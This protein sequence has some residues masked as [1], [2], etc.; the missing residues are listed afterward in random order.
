VERIMTAIAFIGFGEVGATLADDLASRAA[1]IAAW[2]I[3]FPDAE[4][5]PSQAVAARAVR[6]A[7][8]AADALHGADLI[9]SAVTAAQTDAAAGDAAPALAAGAIFLDLNSASP[10][11]K[12]AAAARVNDAGARYIEAAVM[13][14][15]EPKRIAAP[16][17]LGGPYA[18]AVLPLLKDFGFAGASFYSDGYGQAAAAKLC[19][20]I[21]IKGMEALLAE[22]LLTARHYG[23]ED[24]VLASLSNLLP[25]PDWPERARYMI[26]RALEHGVRRAEEMREAARTVEEAGLAPLLS[27]AIAQRQDWAATF[28][29]ALEHDDLNA[30]L[31]A[32]RREAQP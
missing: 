19:R 12:R 29:D 21:V 22:S 2:D 31:D 15:I 6:K 8:N 7:S 16:I 10:S 18:E 3:K 17:L 5:G 30:M 9:I 23:V 27:E 26:S 28:A 11:A 25:A 32:I 13:A 20:S 1:Q 24:S 4:S 14:P